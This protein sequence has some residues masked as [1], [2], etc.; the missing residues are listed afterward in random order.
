MNNLAAAV[1]TNASGQTVVTL[2]FTTTGN[3]A[4][5]IDPV[6][7]LNGGAASLAD[8]RYQLTVNASFVTGSQGLLFDGDNNGTAGG[9]YVSPADTYG[10]DRHCTCTASSA[11]ST[12]TASLTRPTWVCSAAHFNSGLGNPLYVS[13]LDADNSGAVDASDLGQFRSRFNLNVF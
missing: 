3:A 6:S 12:A 5:E 11:T 4:T 7:A 9:N 1:S 13:Y 8:G 10:G 2:T